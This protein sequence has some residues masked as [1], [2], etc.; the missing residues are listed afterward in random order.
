LRFSRL[1]RCRYCSS[2]F[3]RR[4]DS[5]VDTNISGPKM[6]TACFSE[7]SVSTY[8]ST[9]Y[10]NPEEEHQH[11]H[12]REN[13]KSRNITVIFKPWRWRQHVSPKRRYIPT[14]LHGITTQKNNIN[15]YTSV[16]TSNLI[17]LQLYLSPEDGDGKLLRNVSIYLRIYTV[18]KP[19]RRTLTSSPPWEPQISQYYSYI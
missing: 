18:S 17:I 12:R 1:W 9:W 2:G 6:E 11:L 15:I 5:Q 14:N 13:L 3:W 16:R 7:T 8:E 4:V 19:R 10:H